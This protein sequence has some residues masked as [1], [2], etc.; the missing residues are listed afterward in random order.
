MAGINSWPSRKLSY[1]GRAQLVQTVL[2]GVQS[3]WA[4]L[5]IIPAKVIKLIGGLCRSY[6]W[7]GVG[8]ITKKALVAWDKVCS[9]KSMGGMRLINMQLWNKATTAKLSWDLAHKEDKLWIKWVHNFYIKG[10]NPWPESK[11][12]SWMIRKTINGEQQRTDWK[13]LMF[14]NAGRPKA[15]FITWLMLHE[16]LPTTDMLTKWGMVVSKRLWSRLLK[17]VHQLDMLPTNWDQFMHWSIQHAKGKTISAHIFKIIMAECVYG[18]WIERNNR[19]FVQKSRTIGSVESVAKE[20]AYVS[21]I[22]SQSNIKVV[23]DLV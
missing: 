5:F 19:I 12:A 13:C 7:S 8:H 2:F 21:I 22:R 20:I 23:L 18:I 15:Y 14:K 1:A 6:L 3:Y 9:P 17:W 11:Q 16:K 10:K 4:Q